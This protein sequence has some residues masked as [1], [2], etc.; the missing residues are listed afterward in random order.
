MSDE[1]LIE[2]GVD[3][4]QQRYDATPAIPVKVEGPV[5]THELPARTASMGS[6]TAGTTDP[7]QIVSADPRRKSVLV[8]T[9]TQAVWVAL[10]RADAAGSAGFSLP[11]NCGVTLL[12]TGQVWVR[13]KTG[14]ATVS[15]VVENWA[16]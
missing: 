7:T 5:S 1:E 2:P 3:E 15:Y 9:E 8:F 16:D 13:S 6:T 12:H 4:V 11:V 14:T 10:T